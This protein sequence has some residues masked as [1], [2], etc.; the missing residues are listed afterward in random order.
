MLWIILSVLFWPLVL[1]LDLATRKHRRVSIYARKM[2]KEAVRSSND[3]LSKF[4]TINFD[5][6]VR[7]ANKPMYDLPDFV[8]FM[9][10]VYV[11]QAA[12][13]AAEYNDIPSQYHDDFAL[14]Q[15]ARTGCSKDYAKHIL[16]NMKQISSD[17]VLEGDSSPFRI[18]GGQ[19]FKA[20]AVNGDAAAVEYIQKAYKAWVKA[21]KLQESNKDFLDL[22]LS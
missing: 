2:G 11:L 15:L 21:E 13:I 22:V 4:Y 3:Q 18:D 17:I 12:K 19:A 1:A 7:M 6:I 9:S 16:S 8:K 10:S 20:W 14:N 5:E